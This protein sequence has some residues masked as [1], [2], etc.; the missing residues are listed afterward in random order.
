MNTTSASASL[1][2]ASAPKKSLALTTSSRS[3]PRRSVTAARVRP[4]LRTNLCS[5]G[6]SASRT[7]STSLPLA[8]NSG[9]VPSASLRCSP[10]P[11]SMAF[12]SSRTQPWKAAR[13]GL[14]KM[15]TISSI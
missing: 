10:L 9:R 14:S 12:A 15:R 2:E 1:R 6:S 8:T 13:V 7:S 3:C 4:E 5:A 11:F